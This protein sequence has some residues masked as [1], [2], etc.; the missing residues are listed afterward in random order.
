MEC[1]N[2]LDMACLIQLNTSVLIC[3]IKSFFKLKPEIFD[4]HNYYDISSKIYILINIPIL[5]LL[6]V[7]RNA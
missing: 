5:Q 1:F 2:I 3:S 6:K 4:Y 7:R